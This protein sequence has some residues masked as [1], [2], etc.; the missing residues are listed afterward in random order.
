[1]W[2]FQVYD[3]LPC[4]SWPYCFEEHGI[5]IALLPDHCDLKVMKDD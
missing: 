1:M 4:E 5:G 3:L 2:I